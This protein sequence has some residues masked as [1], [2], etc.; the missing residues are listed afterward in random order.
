M[1]PTPL[2]YDYRQLK[3]W[4]CFRLVSDLVTLCLMPVSAASR[5]IALLK[6][7]AGGWAENKKNL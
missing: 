6:L 5:L 3:S 4:L 2:R 1:R 7:Y